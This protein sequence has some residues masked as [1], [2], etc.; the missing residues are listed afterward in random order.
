MLKFA[1]WSVKAPDFRQKTCFERNVHVRLREKCIGKLGNIPG[2]DTYGFLQ[3]MKVCKG[4]R[5]FFQIDTNM[6]VFTAQNQFAADDLY[7]FLAKLF[8]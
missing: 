6:F 5:A 7:L 8:S 4:T 3:R 1:K 2:S